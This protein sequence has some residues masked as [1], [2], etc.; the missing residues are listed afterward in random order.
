MKCAVPFEKH[1]DR[2]I[3]DG[4]RRMQTDAAAEELSG[5]LASHFGKLIKEIEW[6][7]SK[8]S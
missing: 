2:R 5:S 6:R 7:I 3:G 4:L 1:T 8:H